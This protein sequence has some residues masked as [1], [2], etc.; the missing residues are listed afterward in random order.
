MVSDAW[1]ELSDEDERR[2]WDE[3]DRRFRFRPGMDPERWPA[4]AAP[5]GAVVLDLAEIH[6]PDR[7]ESGSRRVNE[8]VLTS[9]QRI[10]DER[11]ALVALDWQHPG[12]RFWPHRHSGVFTWPE[13]P[14]SPFPDGD[15]YLFLTEDMSQGTFGHPWEQTLTVWGDDL[16]RDLVPNWDFR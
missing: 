2:L 13:S 10:F 14:F 4:I 11:T 1:R 3:F 6:H 15:Y 5:P 9:F 16:V 12:Y 7:F 8:L